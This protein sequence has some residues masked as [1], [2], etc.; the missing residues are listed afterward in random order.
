MTGGQEIER[1]EG[2]NVLGELFVSTEEWNVW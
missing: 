1:G 2:L